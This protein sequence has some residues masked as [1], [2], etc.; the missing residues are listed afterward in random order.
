MDW[1]IPNTNYIGKSAGYIVPPNISPILTD[2]T[3][4]NSQIQ[5]HPEQNFTIYDGTQTDSQITGYK[6][7]I[8]WEFPKNQTNCWA[9]I[10][11][12]LQE[13]KELLSA[14]EFHISL[15]NEKINNNTDYDVY[16]QLGV[17]ADNDI[18][19]EESQYIP[20]WKI[21]D[22]I[23]QD[24]I[25]SFDKTKEGWQIVKIKIQENDLIRFT[26]NQNARIII[27]EKNTSTE[28][29]KGTIS[30]GPY[31]IITQSFFIK[32]NPDIEILSKQ[33]K[34]IP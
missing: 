32:E 28:N 23:E 20:T 3:S 17:Q 16:L 12:N 5:L 11:I 8:S 33:K 29:T 13:K 18:D 1:D 30:I 27:Y 24:I 26:Q 31:E 2:R 25:N 15:K 9:G 21:S 10:S 4:I 14:Q 6:I 34:I 22:E 19:Y 7:P